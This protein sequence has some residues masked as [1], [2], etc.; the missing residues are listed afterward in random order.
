MKI[1]LC[2]SGQPRG[3][4]L[5][6]S[7]IQNNIIKPNNISDVFFHAWHNEKDVGKFYNSAQ[8]NQNGFVGLVK[9]N[10]EDTLVNTLKPKLFLVEPQR[11]FLHLRNLIQEPSANQEF[12]GSNFFS[13]WSANELKR[14]YEQ[15]Q[16]FLYDCVI[17]TRY[18][19]FYNAPIKVKDYQEKITGDN[20]VLM[21]RFQND[22]DSKNNSNQPMVDIFAFGSSKVMDVFSSV[23][24]NMVELNKQISPRFGENYLGQHIRVNNKIALHK[25]PFEFQI[26][27]RV[28]KNI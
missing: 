21:E 20:I 4:P 3:I 10:T 7:F 22:Q 8:S 18:D 11:D 26:M 16:G 19:L 14:Q 9:P 13:V 24:P 5:C 6:L 12:L 23:Y 17:R 27:H 25:A 15:E 28:L 1:A 2:L